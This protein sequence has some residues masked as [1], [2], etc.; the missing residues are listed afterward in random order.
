[1]PTCVIFDPTYAT[2]TDDVRRQLALHRHVPLLDVAGPEIA[3]DGE[4]ALSE[5]RVRRERNRTDARPVAPG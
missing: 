4:H 2:S 1:M 3:V 5:P